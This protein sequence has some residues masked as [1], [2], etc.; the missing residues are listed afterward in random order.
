M[1]TTMMIASN[2]SNNDNN[3]DECTGN[4]YE[5]THTTWLTG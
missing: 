2:T 5:S 1:H 4:E 3:Q